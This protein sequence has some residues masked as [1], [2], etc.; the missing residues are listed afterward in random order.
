METWMFYSY[1]GG[2]GRT[3]ASANV[4]AAMAKLGKRVLIIDMDFEAP[5]LHSVFLV[6]E[7]KKFKNKRGIQDYLRGN[8]ETG[9]IREELIIDLTSE[10]GLPEHF[11]I[12][13][14]ACL[15][16]LMASPR[17]SVVFTGESELHPKM[18]EL[19]KYI[20]KKEG[21]DY[22]ILDAASGIRES[23]TLSIQ[24]CDKL[25]IFFKWSRQHLEGTIRVIKLMEVMK[26]VEGG[27]WRPYNLVA[28]AVPGEKDLGNLE[29]QVLARALK[30]AKIESQ[31]K[32]SDESGNKINHIFEIPEIIEL[33]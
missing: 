21:L 3:V 22:I 31:K 27:I 2:S 28:S 1:K 4:A 19:I 15:L 11:P 13:E 9:S 10:E 29:D 23:F 33:K 12:P 26:D 16:Y 20:S 14:Q 32:L 7:T 5:G 18:E 30:G 24:V 6:E 25:I 8:I 17:S